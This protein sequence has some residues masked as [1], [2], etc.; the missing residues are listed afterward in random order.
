M[1]L[2]GHIH[3]DD[4]RL[5]TDATGKAV[6]TDKVVPAISPIFGQNPGFE[7]FSYDL[8]TGVP[9][10][11]TTTY[12][13]N[14]P[15]LSTT[16]AGDWREEYRFAKA[17]GLPGYS[18]ESVAALWKG[19]DQ[20]GQIRDAYIDLYN[21][22]KGTLGADDLKGYACAVGHLDPSS[23]AACYCGG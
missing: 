18:V 4:Y 2:S 14:L 13:A 12:L 19:L 3:F 15:S 5:L 9:T 7:M 1:S 23:Y 10:D 17:Y 20:P 6:E 21:V 11:F 16:V 8:K 22:G